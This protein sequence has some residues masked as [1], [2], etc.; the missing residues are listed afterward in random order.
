MNK[1]LI[2]TSV[3][4]ATIALAGCGNDTQTNA[5]ASTSTAATTPVG[6]THPMEPSTTPAQ[7]APAA[8]VASYEIPPFPLTNIQICDHYASEARRCLNQVASD[9]KR[10]AYEKDITTLLEKVT[11]EPGQAANEWLTSDCRRG[12]DTLAK[13][14]PQCTIQK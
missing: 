4:L 12:L 6:V 5:P 10:H 14:F 13:R 7:A 2:A 11:P 8:T 9:D 3:L 1:Y